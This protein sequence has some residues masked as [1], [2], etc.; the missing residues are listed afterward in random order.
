MPD[1][2][3]PRPDL[4]EVLSVSSLNRSVGS[5]LERQYPLVWVRGEISNFVAAASGHWYFSLKDAQAQVR[6]VMFRARAA[7]TDVKPRNG[8]QIEV[9]AKLT[10][11]EARGDFQL[12][13]EVMRSVGKGSLAEQ[14][15]RLKERLLAQGL[16]D[17]ERK[18]PIP[19]QVQRIAVITSSKGAALR[20]VLTTL[21]RRAPQTLVVFIPSQVQGETAPAQLIDAFAQLEKLNKTAAAVQVVLLVRG[22]GSLEDLWAFNNEQLAHSIAKCSVPVISGVGHETDFTIADFVADAR[23][24]TPTAAAQMASSDRTDVIRRA[25]SAR[26][27]LQRQVV[28]LQAQTRQRLDFAARLLRSPQQQL[29]Q[30]RQR[31]SDLAAGLTQVLRSQVDR[32]QIR[33]ADAQRLLCLP[34]TAQPRAATLGMARRLHLVQRAHLARQRQRVA[35]AA[36]ALRLVDPSAVLERG[37]AIV[38]TKEHQVV[39]Q[40]DQVTAGQ[41]LH[42]RLHQG[43]LDATVTNNG[44]TDATSNARQAQLPSQ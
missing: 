9:R 35:Q 43:R 14:F 5:M 40:A 3:S 38:Q 26:I 16:F 2:D 28:R 34:S 33:L 23:A 24:A 15:E 19:T 18:R 31:V 4:T 44:A 32:F 20:D 8:D 1:F 7:L 42:I 27:Q 36:Q 6:A 39:T 13:V 17:I 10:L 30:Q 25:E 21:A 41:S 29:Q 12:S 37:Y 22:G 11:Y